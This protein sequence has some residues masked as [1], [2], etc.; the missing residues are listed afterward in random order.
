MTLNE[1]IGVDSMEFLSTI[2]PDLAAIPFLLVMFGWLLK[3]T[4]TRADKR[5]DKLMEQI[6]KQSAQMDRI[7]DSLESLEV[8]VRQLKG[9]K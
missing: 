8:Q 6:E 9:V 7:V 3:Y 2:P 5:E 1:F 4:I